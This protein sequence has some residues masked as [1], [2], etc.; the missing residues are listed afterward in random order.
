MHTNHLIPGVTPPPAVL[1]ED[2]RSKRQAG[3]VEADT[4]HDDLIR[5]LWAA[6]RH[7][8]SRRSGTL[9]RTNLPSERS[10]EMEDSTLGY[11]AQNARPALGGLDAANQAV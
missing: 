1:A 7:E 11:L 2:G 4:R 6:R 5:L 8:S 3:A 10:T 9:P